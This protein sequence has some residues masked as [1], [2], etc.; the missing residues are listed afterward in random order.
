MRSFSRG[1]TIIEVLL[2]ITV[3][4]LVAIGALTIMN[5]GVNSA[6]RAQEITLVRQQ[7]DGQAEAL[8]SAQQ[9]A[10]ASLVGQPGAVNWNN[11]KTTIQ[12]TT[13]P[14]SSQTS[15]PTSSAD[16]NAPNTSFIMDPRKGTLVNNVTWFKDIN[17]LSARPYA[18]IIYNGGNVEAYGMWIERTKVT[19]S[20]IQDAYDFT[21]NACWYS[22]GF[23]VPIHLKTLVRLY[24][25]V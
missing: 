7:I 4:S 9:A 1:D 22:A 21:I 25:V 13:S 2:A 24:D 17:S 19:A 5:Q 6:Q 16:I 20:G 12:D 18:Q 23:N 14:Y 3:F 10:A 11:I 15:C 8:R